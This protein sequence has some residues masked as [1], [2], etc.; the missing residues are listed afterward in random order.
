[1]HRLVATL[2]QFGL[3][4]LVASGMGVVADVSWWSVV[5]SRMREGVGVS[6]GFGGNFRIKFV[7]GLCL[8]FLERGW[9]GIRL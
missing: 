7:A 4:S 2:D 8:P 6:I 3:S 5:V 1:M 9:N